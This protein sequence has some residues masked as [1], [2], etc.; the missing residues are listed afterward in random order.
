MFESFD[1]DQPWLGHVA[2][3]GSTI[4]DGVYLFY[5]AY[6]DQIGTHGRWQAT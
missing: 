4:A 5:V 1:P 2:T 6:F 3:T